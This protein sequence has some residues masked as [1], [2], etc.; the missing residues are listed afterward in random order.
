MTRRILIV[1][2]NE[3]FATMLRQGLEEMKETQAN[4][5]VTGREALQAIAA[6]EYDLVI[7]DLDLPDVQATLLVRTLRHKYP[8]LRLAVIP[9]TGEEVPPELA[10]VGLQG[11][12][13]KPFFLPELPGRIRALLSL[14]LGEEPAA[15]GVSPVARE[16]LSQATHLMS[17]LAQEVRAEA[18]LLTQGEELLAQAG[19]LPEREIA[20]LASVVCDSWRTSARVA[21]ILGKEQIRFEQSIEGAEHLLYSL[22]LADDLILSVV[23]RGKVPLGMIRHRAKETA[24]ALRELM[25]MR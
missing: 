10:D 21:Q 4:V 3:A 15:G 25:G 20:A 6:V 2:A 1:D 8:H 14:P 16:R 13:P 19:R 11:V 24:E 5:V 7:V 23:V 17:R 18:V 9:L 12:L 22:A